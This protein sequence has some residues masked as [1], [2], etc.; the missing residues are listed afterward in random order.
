M[1]CRLV[2]LDSILSVHQTQACD[3][4]KNVSLSLCAGD[5]TQALAA[6]AK[7]YAFDKDPKRLKRL[8]ANVN[9][10]GAREIVTVTQADF[11]TIDPEAV[12]YS[13]VRLCISCM[14]VN[15]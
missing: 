6:D 13:K 15:V 12:L 14:D 10:T 3:K 8:Q 1:T 4:L 9:T 2:L 5:T 7:V 11:L